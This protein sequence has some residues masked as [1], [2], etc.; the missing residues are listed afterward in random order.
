MADDD[1]VTDRFACP[2]C[3]ERN[4]DKLV[5]IEDDRV[6]CSNCSTVYTV[7]SDDPFSAN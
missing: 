1:E 3:G 4:A 5:W 6:Q 7:A 2:I